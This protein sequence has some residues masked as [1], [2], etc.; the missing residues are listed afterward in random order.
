MKKFQESLDKF[1]KIS[2]RGSTITKELIGGLTIFLAMVYIL[3]V[4]GGI[5]SATGMDFAAVFAATAIAAAIASLIMGLYANYPVGLASGM[6]VNAFFTYVVV[7][8]LQFTWEEALAAVLISGVLFLIISITGIRKKVINSI[9]NN[10][11][12]SVGAGIGFFIAFL[13]FK[14]AGIITSHPETFVKLGNLGHETVL[15]A[16]FGVLLVFILYALNKKISRFAIIISIVATG[17]LGVLLGV[18]FPGLE[19]TMPSIGGSNLGSISNVGQTFGK[20]FGAMGSLLSKPLAYA[21]IFT[22]LFVDFFDTAGTL[23]AVGHDAG[24]LDE[25]GELIDGDKALVADSV[26]TIVGAVVGTS[27]VTSYIESTTGIESGARTGLSATVVGLLF[28]VSLLFFPLFSFVQS[29]EVSPGVFYSPVTSMALIFVGALMVTSLKDIDWNDNIVVSSS[30]ITVIIMV[31]SASIAEG[32]AFGFII[33]AV[34]MGV[35]KRR[36]EVSPV[37]YILAGLFLINF[38]IKYLFLV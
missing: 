1:F 20:A 19:A 12:L 16:I 22:F 23:V 8:E 29:I 11:K 17:L 24:L 30:F 36:K 25:N 26:G 2:Q 14:N 34:M 32:I 18:I 21:V 9:P 10:L 4:N 38:I 13:G 3:P 5:L 35:T 15:L 27:T 7:K 28:I 6:G 31:L 37:M 33:Y